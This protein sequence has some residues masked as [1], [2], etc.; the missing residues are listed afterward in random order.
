MD[1]WGR[2]VEMGG[3]VS[4]ESIIEKKTF[5]RRKEEYDELYKT[6]TYPVCHQPNILKSIAIVS[7]NG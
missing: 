5:S 1:F 3:R 6:I 4:C 2:M 7:Q